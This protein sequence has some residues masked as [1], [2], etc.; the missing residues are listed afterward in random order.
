MKETLLFKQIVLQK[1]SKQNSSDNYKER[2]NCSYNYQ[3]QSQIDKL[4]IANNYKYNTCIHGEVIAKIIKSYDDYKTAL[5]RCILYGYE[6][7]LYTIIDKKNDTFKDRLLGD[8]QMYYG[9]TI[10]EYFINLT[11][12]TNNEYILKLMCYAFDIE[13]LLPYYE[14][15]MDLKY[16]ENKEFINTRR[17]FE[18][19]MKNMDVFEEIFKTTKILYDAGKNAS[20]FIALRTMIEDYL[21]RTLSEQETMYLISEVKLYI[22][23]ID[24]K[25]ITNVKD[26]LK[27]IS[28][29]K[30][31]K[32]PKARLMEYTGRVVSKWELELLP[33]IVYTLSS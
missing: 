13:Y 30:L 6:R 9:E 26:I 12:I 17:D 28:I 32:N 14:N 4:I 18:Y 16:I 11:I 31:M 3:L 33:D 15:F 10:K 22:K 27:K 23:Y 5:Y 1:A 19:I 2:I 29:R 7:I 8:K 25:Y 20:Y 24:N 21:E